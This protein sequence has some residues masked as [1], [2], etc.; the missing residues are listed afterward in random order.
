MILSRERM[1]VL[2]LKLTNYF[3]TESHLRKEFFIRPPFGQWR[4][5][6][7]GVL[8]GKRPTGQMSGH[9]F[10]KKRQKSFRPEANQK[11]QRYCK[12]K[13]FRI[14]IENSKSKVLRFP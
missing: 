10:N 11:Y 6:E 12:K 1:T 2:L 7:A 8:I 9:G 14:A 4:R 13:E 5:N 3:L